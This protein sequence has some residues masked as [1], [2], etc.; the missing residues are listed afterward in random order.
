MVPKL[1]KRMFVPRVCKACRGLGVWGLEL[2]EYIS[3]DASF[4]LQA[5][6]CSSVG[7]RVK[8]E[9]LKVQPKLSPAP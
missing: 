1:C 4:L 5:W 8:A 3:P 7:P 9:K 2:R 6:F